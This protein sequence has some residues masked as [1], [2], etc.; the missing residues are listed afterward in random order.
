MMK[1]VKM[2]VQQ[3]RNVGGEK[4]AYIYSNTLRHY[5]DKRH[6]IAFNA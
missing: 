4:A 5:M 3:L 6:V 1:S 2:S